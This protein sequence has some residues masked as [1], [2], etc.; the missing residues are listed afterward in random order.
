MSAFN[1]FLALCHMAHAL[2]LQVGTLFKTIDYAA[3]NAGRNRVCVWQAAD[4]VEL[5]I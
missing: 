1:A 3:K 2:S 4:G 5:V